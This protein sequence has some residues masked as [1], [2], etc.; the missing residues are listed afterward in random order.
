MQHWL[1]TFAKRRGPHTCWRWSPYSRLP[2]DHA[3]VSRRGGFPAQESRMDCGLGWRIVG[4]VASKAH[5]GSACAYAIAAVCNDADGNAFSIFSDNDKTPAWTVGN[6]SAGQCRNG[7]WPAR[8]VPAVHCRSRWSARRSIR[9]AVCSAMPSPRTAGR[10]PRTAGRR[11]CHQQRRYRPGVNRSG[12]GSGRGWQPYEK[13]L[14]LAASAPSFFTFLV[15]E[16]VADSGGLI[17]LP[18]LLGER[19]RH[20]GVRCRGDYIGPSISAAGSPQPPE[21]SMT[22]SSPVPGPSGTQ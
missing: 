2:G 6:R 11:R 3:R 21:D 16:G 13:L 10:E 15:T 20:S 5:A 18:H 8:S 17:M 4:A 1:P 12:S 7:A 14:D 19:A 22:R 9:P